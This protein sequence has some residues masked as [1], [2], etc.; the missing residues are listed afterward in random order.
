MELS[1]RSFVAA[2]GATAAVSV[3][4]AGRLA[5]ASSPASAEEPNPE[6]STESAAASEA[7]AREFTWPGEEPQVDESSIA[8]TI[9]TDVLICGAGHTGMIAAVSAAQAGA[10]TVVIE[11]NAQVG[12]TRS[13]IGAIN[14]RAQRELGI[15]I[16]AQA[17][18]NDL[19]RYASGRCNARL[20]NMWANES[21]AAL[22]WLENAVKDY[23]IEMR[24]EPAGADESEGVYMRSAIHHRPILSDTLDRE[25]EFEEDGSVST[26]AYWIK[27]LDQSELNNALV[28]V[29]QNNGAQFLFETPLV[30]LIKDGDGKVV[31]A[32]AQNSDGDYIRVNASRGVVLCC[33]GYA[34]DPVVY[35]HLDYADY[36]GT[37]FA[38]V[39]PGDAG[40]GIRAGIWAG[41][42]KDPVPTAMLFDRG[43]VTPNQSAGVDD[44]G[45]YS[46]YPVW[47]ASQPW[48][49]LDLDGKRFCNE[50]APYDVSLHSLDGRREHLEVILWDANAWNEIKAF[51]TI[52]CSR[53][54]ESPT[55][56]PTGEGVGEDVFNG[57]VQEGLDMG[58]VYKEDTV[59]A[60]AEDL[61]I[62]ADTMKASIDRYNESAKAGVDDEFGKPG[63]DLFA[64]DTPPFYGARV[65]SWV[66][67]TLDG[68][69]I[70]E[71]CRVLSEE[72]GEPIEGLYACGD[73]SGSFFCNNYP[74]LHPGVACGRGMTEARHATLHALGRLGDIKSWQRD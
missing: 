23:G 71:D 57:W 21:G 2:A 43:G 29:A 74:E 28:E 19:V 30:K 39:Q 26:V 17:V 48:L 65:G 20:I 12:T 27:K 45:Q 8:E 49:K 35:S 60:L 41:G 7:D 6:S 55:E 47:Y 40:D 64:L 31:G 3:A 25:P 72:T 52:S 51:N 37:T 14:T 61:H 66:L 15:E 73:N 32:I 1:R 46:G 68:L 38:L 67:C 9:D 69:Q 34:S 36:K 62:P 16:D 44:T 18:V 53:L 5:G 59:E 4:G 63:K 24:S 56:P 11:K 22:D 50:S 10:R 70:D 54:V 13:Y 42:V 58:L 33:G